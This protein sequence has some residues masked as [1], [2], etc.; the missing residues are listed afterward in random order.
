MI[1]PRPTRVLSIALAVLVLAACAPEDPAAPAGAE[2]EAGATAA[3]GA[4]VRTTAS[5]GAAPG[6]GF[7]SA[8]SLTRGSSA[9]A[10]YP[11]RGELLS[12]DGVRRPERQGGHSFYPTRVS[13]A[14]ALAAISSGVLSLTTPDGRRVELQYDS[15]VEHE[16]GDWSWIGRDSNGVDGILTF[17]PDAVFG[18]LPSGD[19]GE[20]RLTTSAGQAWMVTTDSAVRSPLQQRIDVGTSRPDFLVPTAAVAGDEVMAASL[21]SM[22]AGTIEAEA[23]QVQPSA[24]GTTLDVLLG[25]TPGFAT[26]LGGRSQAVTRLNHIV[27]VG[28]QTFVNSNV[29]VTLRLTG[30]MEVDYPDSGSNQTALEQLTGSDGE[31]NVTIP[32]SLRP[33]RQARDTQGADLVSL[34][35]RFRDPDHE[36]CGIAW[37][38]GGGQREIVAGHE[39]F[40]YSVI[41]DSNG[42]QSPDNGHYC[43]DE[44]LVHELGHNLGSQHDRE[45]ATDEDG[46]TY[47]RYAYSFGYKTGTSGGNF[48]TVMA[49]GDEGQTPYRVFSNPQTTYCGGRACGVANQADNARSLRQTAPLIA[50]FRAS[51][52]SYAGPHLYAIKRNGTVGTEVHILNGSR[53]YGYFLRQMRTA[54]ARTGDGYNW[55]FRMGDYNRDGVLDLY[56]IKK[57]GGSGKTEVHILNGASNFSSY[58]LQ[59]TTLLHSTGSDNRWQ[60]DLG[61]YNGDGRPDLFAIKR[62]AGSGKTEVHVLNG[63]NFKSYLLQTATALGTTG[64]DL[65]WKFEV[66]DYNRDGKLDL[67]GI[68]RNGGS[69]RTEV[70][71]LNGANRFKSFLLQ[72]ATL[73]PS[74]GRQDDWDFKLGDL[75]RDGRPDLFAIEKVGSDRTMIHVM[76]GNGRFREFL[77]NESSAL[78]PTGETGAWQFDLAGP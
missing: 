28:N 3:T 50:G 1:L 31:S 52:V 47:G 39:R 26:M 11:D 13:E 72:S 69:G 32:A 18:V 24:T 42:M 21:T 40:G 44:T 48:Y 57:N 20:L 36:G 62:M 10:A 54:L 9:L 41:S 7:M 8:S 14:H 37:M 67:Y 74:T 46:L 68:K 5:M 59:T 75:D 63:T 58:L 60:F 73:L 70:H 2:A 25:Y 6:S 19:G 35:R 61:H 34:V 43:R 56:A 33:L 30:T 22:A 15:Y 17:G 78:N 55:A 29:A 77:A 66:G 12:Y 71:V 16:S 76:D 65:G 38:I 27:T 64:S 49:Y 45:A 53:R 51:K 4:D 23:A